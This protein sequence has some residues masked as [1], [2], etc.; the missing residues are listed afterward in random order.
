MRVTLFGPPDCYYCQGPPASQ[1]WEE[2]FLASRFSPD[3]KCTLNLAEYLQNY[4]QPFLPGNPSW[5]AELGFE[6]KNQSLLIAVIVEAIFF[7]LL[8]FHIK[9]RRK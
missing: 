5:K 7:Q 9:H 6:A 4:P 1:P 3:A 8:L 2:A